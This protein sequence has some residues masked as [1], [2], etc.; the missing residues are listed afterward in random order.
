MMQSANPIYR[1]LLRVA[2]IFAV[3]GP[4]AAENAR[5]A[6]EDADIDSRQRA[7]SKDTD[8]ISV[9]AEDRRAEERYR[10]KAVEIAL[11]TDKA[12]ASSRENT[13]LLYYQALL[14]YR[15]PDPCTGKLF[16]A[17]QPLKCAE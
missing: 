12:A 11:R 2:L 15:E 4:V 8:G 5:K 9:S 14:A 7:A 17:V 3:L 10:E 1:P 16:I 6:A 13:A